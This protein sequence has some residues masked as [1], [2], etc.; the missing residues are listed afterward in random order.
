M[1]TLL[2]IALLLVLVLPTL[3]MQRRQR[4]AMA[5]IQRVQDEL[6]IGDHIITN[7]GLHA[8]VR[9]IEENTVDLEVSPGQT[10][11]WEKSAVLRN[12]SEEQRITEA[13]SQEQAE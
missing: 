7:A 13:A 8:V 6:V 12:V 11:V 4:Q 1:N 3:L 10:V 5:K 9:G 2:F